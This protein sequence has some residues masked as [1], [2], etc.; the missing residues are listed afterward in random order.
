MSEF[1]LDVSAKLNEASKTKLIKDLESQNP[2]MVVKT[3][4][5]GG[6]IKEV[7]EYKDELNNT[8]NVIKTY[9]KNM[10]QVGDTLVKVKGQSEE[11]R[12]ELEKQKQASEQAK[13]AQKKLNLE[14]KEA[15]KK[16]NLEAKEAQKKLNLEAKEAEQTRIAEEKKLNKAVTT[17]SSSYIDKQG[18]RVTELKK[19]NAEGKQVGD[20]MTHISE[21]A[22]SSGKSVL[23]LGKDFVDTTAKVMKFYASTLLIQVFMIAINEAVT[24]VHEMDDAIVEFQKVSNLSGKSLNDYVKKLGE[25]GVKTGSTTKAMIEASTEFKKSGYSDEDSAKL[26]SVT[27]MYRNVADEELTAGQAASFIISQMKAFNIS[28]GESTHI[29]DAVNEV[30]ILAFPI[31]DFRVIKDN[32]IG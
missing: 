5:K 7:K 31:R 32:C 11:Y 15:Q 6:G 3:E 9:D 4:L 22:N 2:T 14:A 23:E 19:F 17:T 28:A 29:I 1:I 24:T 27:E 26:A 13:E 18:K 12:K 30:K 16:L 21:R 8:A 25:M 10:K 20:T